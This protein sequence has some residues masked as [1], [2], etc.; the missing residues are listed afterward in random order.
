MSVCVCVCVCEEKE[1]VEEKEVERHFRVVGFSVHEVESDQDGVIHDVQA[2]K[3]LHTNAPRER[4][5]V[6]NPFEE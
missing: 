2:A 5:R 4:P 6:K 3:E 1:E